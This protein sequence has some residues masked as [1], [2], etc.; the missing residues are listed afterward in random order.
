[1]LGRL[2]GFLV[3]DYGIVFGFLCV[4]DCLLWCGVCRFLGMA[5]LG[6]FVVEFCVWFGV[7]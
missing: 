3:F 7:G 1:M 2:C 5:S 6:C 4:L